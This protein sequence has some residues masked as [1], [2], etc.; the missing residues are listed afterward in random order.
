MK[1][2]DY[3]ETKGD[4][5]IQY[6]DDNEIVS[7]TINIDENSLN[8]DALITK[9]IVNN[10]VNDI[11]E[12][13]DENI[14]KFKIIE[15]NISIKYKEVS[16]Y[17]FFESF[18]EYNEVILGVESKY[19]NVADNVN[20]GNDN[21]LFQ[22][23][24]KNSESNE[25]D[26]ASYILKN[27]F[28]KD[29]RTSDNLSPIGYYKEFDILCRCFKSNFLAKKD[30]RIED[31]YYCSIPKKSDNEN[32]CL[33]TLIYEIT[34]RDVSHNVNDYFITNNS[35]LVRNRDIV[36]LD[37]IQFDKNIIY[38]YRDKLLNDGANSVLLY[39]FGKSSIIWDGE[40]NEL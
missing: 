36:L 26:T 24:Y 22:F 37:N 32:K 25:K 10:N 30:A 31:Y 13:V 19:M 15:K 3:A 1:I 4:F 6:L 21:I 39:T 33:D 11:V 34:K 14:I 35:N 40:L 16:E 29:W 12:V 38:K 5:K 28:T 18:K 20:P 23:Y 9:Q 27:C 8:L 7:G 17:D 2:I